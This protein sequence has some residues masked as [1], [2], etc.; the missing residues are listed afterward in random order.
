MPTITGLQTVQAAFGILNVYLPGETPSA[1]DG[2]FALGRL[3]SMI[4][5]WRQRGA[6]LSPVLARERFDLVA[7][8]GGPDNPY[9]IGTGG[10]FDTERPPNQNSIVSANLI[11]TA[12]SPEV[13]VPLGIYTDTAYAANQLPGMTS[14]QPTSVYYNPTYSAGFGSILL[15]PVPN[16]AINDLELFIQQ[17]LSR[18][19]TLA[20]SLIVPD[21]YDT[22]LEYNL[23]VWLAGPYGK[24]LSDDDKAIARNSFEVVQRSNTKLVDVGNDMYWAS[25]GRRSLFNIE[26]GNG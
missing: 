10:D 23:A 4:S 22:A 19:A 25:Q 15:W 11:L 24:R 26:T 1:N 18:F 16:T 17:M 8:Q 13:R 12:T 6:L 21:G 9:T 14:G 2:S 7:N 20:T 5:S 3:N